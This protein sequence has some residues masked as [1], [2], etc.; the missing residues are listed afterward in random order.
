MSRITRRTLLTGAPA[1]AFAG[2]VPAF[3]A[4]AQESADAY[5][6]R[7]IKFICAFPAGSGADVY[8]RYFAERMRPVMKRNIIVENRA[9]A[10]CEM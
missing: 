9:G 1:L 6:S 4:Y 7:E 5:P 10:S 3:N 8:V 2:S